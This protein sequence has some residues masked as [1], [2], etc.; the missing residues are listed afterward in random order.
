MGFPARETSLRR[1][2]A[3]VTVPPFRPSVRVMSSE[4]W[5][6]CVA[7]ELLALPL[8]RRWAHTRGV[9][10]TAAALAGILGDD[11]A[12]LVAAAWL[13][14][15]GYA[16]GVA[17]TG[18]H[19]L[20]GARY[21]R[22]T[23]HADDL[24]CRLVAH[25]SCAGNEAAERGVTS[26]FPAPPGDLADALTYCDMTTGPDGQRMPVEQRLA[27]ILQRYGPGDVVHRAI[28]RSAPEITAAVERVTRRLN[29]VRA[30]QGNGRD[31]LAGC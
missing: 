11:D 21:L 26:E 15:I 12:L 7:R 19:H 10:A 4:N 17:A 6:E 1:P 24:L 28:T 23:C 16:P 2:A 30:R 14:D 22:D 8:P 31:A 27:E 9:A 3:L 25:H 13:H 20:D 29:H 18:L 5:A